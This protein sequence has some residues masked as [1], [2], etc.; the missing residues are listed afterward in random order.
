V[1]YEQQKESR[2]F[3]KQFTETLG[4]THRPVA[5]SF[6][7]AAP[8]GVDKFRGTEPSGC[9]FW[10]LAGAG[11]TFYTVP[12]DHYNCA[13]GS[14]THSITLPPERAAELEQTLSFMSDIGYIKMEE[15]GGIPR[16]PE[17]PGVI[18][19]A[20]LA[21]SPVAPGVVLFRGTPRQLMLLQEAAQRAGKAAQ[22][23]LLGRPTCMAL[24]AAMANGA[25]MSTGCIGNRVY[26]DLEDDGMYLAVPGNAMPAIAAE[27]RTIVLANAQLTEYH[28]GRRQ[29]LATE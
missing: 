5:I 8:A 20:P 9:S 23:P 22:L 14:H 25:V 12:A 24:P 7:E 3:E 15:V 27:L 28:R 4:L 6:R 1:A 11:R 26:T 17:T 29:A 16:L 21:D 2:Q 10:R 13:V 19:Y 18:I